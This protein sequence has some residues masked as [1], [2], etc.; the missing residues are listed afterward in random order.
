MECRNEWKSR[1]D[2]ECLRRNRGEIV[3]IE[4][5]DFKSF[6]C[7]RA[8]LACVGKSKRQ[9]HRQSRDFLINILLLLHFFSSSLHLSSFQFR[10]S[11][12]PTARVNTFINI[13]FFDIRR[14]LMNIS[15]LFN[16]YLLWKVFRA[17]DIHTLMCVVVEKE[18]FA[19][20]FAFSKSQNANSIYFFLHTHS[21]SSK[22]KYR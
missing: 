16:L 22:S 13:T 2:F 4:N 6:E 8:I 14:R 7:D 21:L 5:I 19:F 10:L 1:N 11:L 9:Y 15:H 3:C 17:F 18:Y 12:P 20:L